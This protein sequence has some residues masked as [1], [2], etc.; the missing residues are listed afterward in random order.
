MKRI[1]SVMLVF[2]AVT[3]GA[4]NPN[5]PPPLDATVEVVQPNKGDA[6][7]QS[8]S[9][10][11]GVE[12]PT[13]NGEAAGNDQGDFT[14]VSATVDQ[15]GIS[16]MYPLDKTPGL[17][18]KTPILEQDNFELHIDKEKANRILKQ[19]R[20]YQKIVGGI[21]D[22]AFLQKP[23]IKPFSALDTIHVPT[24]YITTIVF[25][26]GLVIQYAQSG[27][28]FSI[29]KYDQNVF[30]FQPNRDFQGTNVVVGLSDG[31][32]NYIA[33]IAIEKYLP[34]DIVKDNV[35]ERY[36]TCGEYISTMINYINPPKIK[37]VD[38]IKRY[39][40]LFGDKAIKNFKKNGTFD[41][42]TIQGMPFYII[43][44]D[45]KG[46]IEFQNVSFRVATRYE[47]FA[48]NMKGRR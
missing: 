18:T 37:P 4:T 11:Q 38:V 21:Q 42:I 30:I 39:F 8:I 47:Q 25:P 26:K 33:N 9:K 7:T 36:M 29:N 6:N 45:R 19:Q 28:T 2:G 27:A 12:P 15:T 23:L 17:K 32:K 41:V 1:T 10:V 13:T 35:E 20:R 24:E 22:V 43:R 48:E 44:D 14:G 16:T 3:F 5:I 34:G 46:L 40:S 31:R